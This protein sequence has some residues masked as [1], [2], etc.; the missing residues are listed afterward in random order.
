MKRYRHNL[1]HYC[2][3][4]GD[5]GFL[6]PV[7]CVEVLPGDSFRHASSVLLRVEPLL[8]PVM[9]PV[10]VRVHSFFVPNRILMDNWEEFITGKDPVA[11]IPTI[12]LT[13]QGN[14]GDLSDH[15]GIPWVANMEIN[16]LPVRAYNM[17]FNEFYRDQDLSSERAETAMTLA[18]FSWEKDYFTTCRA[19]AQQGAEFSVPFSAG[20]APVKGISV[21]GTESYPFSAAG[22]EES[23]GVA[24]SG[25]SDWTASG[26]NEWRIQ[27][28][29]SGPNIRADL[30]QADGGI[31]INDLRLA[32]A[33]QRFAEQMQHYGDRYIDYL[34]AWGITPRDGRLDRPEYL[35]G[36]K[37]TI[38]FSEVLATG[39][40]AG[41]T[42]LGD[43]AGHGIAALRTRPYR[44]FFPEH[45]YMMSLLSVRPKTIYSESLHRHWLRRTKDDYYQKQFEILGPQTV[46]TQEVYASADPAT[47]FG[48]NERFREYREIPSYVSGKFRTGQNS[49]DWH[50][51]RQFSVEPALN[52]SF[53]NCDPTDRIYAT[54]T[55]PEIKVMVNHNITARRVVRPAG[56]PRRL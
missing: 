4:T 12:T 46:T 34:R 51:A 53:V 29:A 3:T 17:I 5:M 19:T 39:T 36:G 48:F 27:G 25:G 38:A 6:I 10:D 32:V 45:G 28:D 22:Y 56:L 14:Q 13:N 47:V 50:M 35:G 11:S 15:L 41:S 2:L 37:Q 33:S 21:V 44:R 8:T 40:E 54:T 42:N 9:H 18:R 30:S 16:A 43:F 26:P 1:S 23:P 52:E 49:D 7:S 24:A 20:E 31:A 55:E